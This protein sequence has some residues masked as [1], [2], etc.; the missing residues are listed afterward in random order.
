MM[1][2]L[3]VRIKNFNS[4]REKDMVPV[5]YEA[6]AENMF[7]FYRGTCHLFYEDLAKE[8]K[9]PASPLVWICGDLHLEN[10]GSFKSDNKQVYFDLND[11]DESI[12]APATWE[13]VRFVTSIFVAFKTLKIHDRKALRMAELF[14]KTY[15][16]TLQNG[17][18]FYIE[19]NTAQG[20]VCEFLTAVAKRKQQ[21]LLAKRTEKKKDKLQILSDDQRHLKISK[22]LKK[23]L[24]IHLNHWLKTDEESPYNYKVI[25]AVFRVAGTGS[26]GLKRYSFLLKSSN[27][28]GQKYL[29]IDMKQSVPSSLQPYLAVPQ[30][31]WDSESQR[32]I[33]VQ[34]RMQNRSAA[35]LSSSVFNGDHFVMQEMQPTKDSI[36]FK[37]I[38]NRYRDMY[39]VIDDMA[40]LTASAQLRSTGQDGSTITD[41]L[42]KFGNETEWQPVLIQFAERYSRVVK[43]YY[44]DFSARYKNELIK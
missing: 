10:F 39:R 20:I 26:I 28:V 36:N 21:D 23:E 43:E 15:S 38:K 7:R 37:Q 41:E 13:L 22:K 31:A 12:L 2:E 44:K 8:K 4:S 9:L 27:K 5:K 19:P 18:A 11:F 6:M 42:K 32:I 1:D 40:V 34:Q 17:K 33:T 14:L 30:P 25:D 29:L 35:L 24:S 3:L 16:L